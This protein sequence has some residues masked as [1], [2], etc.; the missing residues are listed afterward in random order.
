MM[1]RAMV[2]SGMLMFAASTMPAETVYEPSTAELIRAWT[3][4]QFAE[5]YQS[6][7]MGFYTLTTDAEKKVLTMRIWGPVYPDKLC[8]ELAQGAYSAGIA[9]GWTI[10]VNLAK[11][12]ATYEATCHID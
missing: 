2:S 7:G 1:T 6:A 12:K 3:L 9:H 11:D 4:V 8:H 5:H 10:H